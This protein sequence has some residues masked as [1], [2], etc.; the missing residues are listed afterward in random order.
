MNTVEIERKKE[1]KLDRTHW[2][3]RL[4]KFTFDID[5]PTYYVG[6]CPFFWMT[7]LALL[8][9]PFRALF[10]LVTI[11]AVQ[12]HAAISRPIKEYR[13]TTLID[14]E[15]IPLRPSLEQMYAIRDLTIDSINA[16]KLFWHS[17]N[18]SFS[19][20]CITECKR[21]VVW[22]NQNPDW[23][24]EWIPKAE[25]WHKAKVEAEAEAEIMRKKR[26]VRLAKANKFASMCGST[27][28]KVVIPLVICALVSFFCYG[29]YTISSVI[30]LSDFILAIA[31]FA[32]FAGCFIST[33][34]LIDAIKTIHHIRSKNKIVVEDVKIPTLSCWDKFTARLAVAIEF[35]RDTVTVT[36]KQECPLIIWGDETSPIQKHVK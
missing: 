30:R 28:F 25:D 3:C 22:L 33:H 11:P 8:I 21:I 26:V 29:L 35:I 27:I 19:F 17:H 31:V 34:I 36:Y 13:R 1:K 4:Q 23:Q 14:L 32:S 7:W 6:Y 9:S 5:A 16:T 20:G 10:N 24:T 18:Y 12:I 2:M 15:M